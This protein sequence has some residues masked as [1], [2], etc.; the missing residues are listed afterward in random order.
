MSRRTS[1]CSGQACTGTTGR[2]EPPARAR[3]D[4]RETATKRVETEH[5]E[6]LAARQ[7]VVEDAELVVVPPRWRAALP[8]EVSVEPAVVVGAALAAATVEAKRPEVEHLLGAE[9]HVRIR[10][11]RCDGEFPAVDLHRNLMRSLAE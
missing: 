7:H 3:R 10:L 6:L 11:C 2:L 4:D 9:L 8:H 1:C 5:L